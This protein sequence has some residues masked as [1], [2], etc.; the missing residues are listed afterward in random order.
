MNIQSV[1]SSEFSA[2]LAPTV[3]SV[4]ASPNIS[5][6][7]KCALPSR[8]AF[9][10]LREV[11]DPEMPWL[12]YILGQTPASIWYWCADQVRWKLISGIFFVCLLE[13]ESLEIAVALSL[14]AKLWYSCKGYICCSFELNS[15]S[16]LAWLKDLENLAPNCL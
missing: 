1:A 12:G 15:P 4:A 8:S 6:D 16:F 5:V 2:G 3:D 11:S 14:S 9:V 7:L 10:M 13:T